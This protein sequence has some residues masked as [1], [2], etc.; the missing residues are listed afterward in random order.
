[1][2][3]WAELETT[4]VDIITIAD[5][6]KRYKKLTNCNR[7]LVKINMDIE[8][9]HSNHPLN[10]NGLLNA[11]DLDLAHDVGGIIQHLN[12][13]SGKLEDCFSPRWSE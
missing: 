7:E 4:T 10:L 13:A 12:R 2:I 3:N 6:A 11:S 1:M 9:A 5:I 8:L